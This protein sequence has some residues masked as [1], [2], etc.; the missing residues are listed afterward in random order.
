MEELNERALVAENE[1]ELI[2][3]KIQ[4]LSGGSQNVLKLAAAIGNKF[5]VST[6]ACVMGEQVSTLPI[7][8]PECMAIKQLVVVHSFKPT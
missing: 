4:R 3:S 5:K 1:I 2:V 8:S 7:P 6:L